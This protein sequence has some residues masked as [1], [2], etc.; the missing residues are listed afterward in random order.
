MAMSGS[1]VGVRILTELMTP[2]EFGKLALGMTAATFVQQLA[3]GPLANG[4]IRYYAPSIEKNELTCFFTAIRKISIFATKII[5]FIFLLISSCLVVIEHG[6]SIPL[7]I[8]ALFFAILNGYNS[9]LNGIQNAARHRS[10]VALHRGLQSW[11]RVFFAAGLLLVFSPSSFMAM[12]GYSLGL[13][14]VLCSQSFFFRKIIPK[15]STAKIDTVK[16]Y[17]TKIMRYSWPIVIWGFFQWARAASDRWALEAFMSSGDVGLYAVLLQLGYNPM[18][19]ITVMATQLL[20]P[21][22]FQRAGEANDVSRIQNVQRMIFQIATFTIA[23]TSIIAVIVYISHDFIFN[24]LVAHKYHSVSYLLPW[25]LFSGGI[26]ATAQIV[27]ISLMSQMK[28]KKL[29]A[30]K[31]CT[32]AIGVVLNFM[33]AYWNGVEG[34]V[35][36][37]VSFTLLY[38]FWVV[39]LSL[40]SSQPYGHRLLN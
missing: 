17:N 18:S 39:I 11:L 14:F 12:S 24:I 30:P 21:I 37:W 16:E 22:F 26:F 3:M 1:F 9:I 27:S 10:I 23:G 31:I 33:G 32:C 15:N 28:T 13:G 19:R 8:S 25:V 38:L 34:V 35:F 7:L 40:K 5:I 6:E 36:A 2:S 4:A 20:S 29:L